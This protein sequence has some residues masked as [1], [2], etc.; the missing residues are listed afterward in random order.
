MQRIRNHGTDKFIVASFIVATVCLLIVA[1]LC[2]TMPSVTAS[3]QT[4]ATNEQ[5]EFLPHPTTLPTTIAGRLQTSSDASGFVQRTSAQASQ[6]T[7]AGIRAQVTPAS[8]T[9]AGIPPG[10]ALPSAS[11]P[12]SVSL[13]LHL[14][15]LPEGSLLRIIRIEMPADSPD[16]RALQTHLPGSSA[17]FQKLMTILASL[18]TKLNNDAIKSMLVH[19]HQPPRLHHLPISCR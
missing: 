4:A 2:F 10:R 6:V 17:S 19:L 5:P 12:I 9:R 14:W 1:Y 11:N 7:I 13:D 8:P 15:D 16:A 3:R 18:D